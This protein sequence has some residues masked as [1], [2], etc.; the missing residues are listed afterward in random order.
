MSK[1]TDS[2]LPTLVVGAGAWGTALAMALARNGHQVWLWGRDEQQRA[3]MRAKHSNERYL[4][5]L[6]FPPTLE[7]IDDFDDAAARCKHVLVAVPS[8]AFTAML[9]RL[10]SLMQPHTPVSWA[11][12]GL[13]PDTGRFL[14]D[15]ASDI[16][17]DTHPLAVISGP[18]FAT[19]VAKNLP[20]AVTV[21]SPNESFAQ[22]LAG[23]LHSPTLRVYT[24]DR[25]SVV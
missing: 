20:T 16:L 19:E 5:G 22:T 10:K 4:P 12:K 17:G 11:T 7:I 18:S 25:K 1:Q 23:V 24:T 2:L 14:Y 6:R 3:E 13:T 21:A 8:I 9:Q 15:T